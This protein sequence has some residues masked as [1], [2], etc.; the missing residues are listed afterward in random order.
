MQIPIDFYTY[1]Q[2]SGIFTLVCLVV[3]ILGFIFRWGIRFRIVGVTGFMLVLTAGLFGL[4]L[5]LFSR[6]QI[7]GAVR[8]SVVYDNGGNQAVIALPPT[9]TESEVEATLRQAA[10]DLFAYGRLLGSDDK[11]TIRA[12]TVI[13]PKADLSKPLYLGQVQRSRSSNPTE[14]DTIEIFSESFAQLPEIPAQS[15]EK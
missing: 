2:W 13:H 11:L 9:V 7:P 4:G 6:P 8:F 12:R 15:V 14:L 1:A 5:G 10:V 3:A